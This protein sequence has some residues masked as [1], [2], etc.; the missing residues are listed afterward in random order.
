MNIL[1]AMDENFV[2][3]YMVLLVSLFE[4]NKVPIKVFLL[5]S[6]LSQSSRDKFQKLTSQY[7]NE[8]ICI[9]EDKDQFSDFSVGEWSVEAF[10]RL[11]AFAKL[12]ELVD[13]IL[14]LDGDVV[15]RQGI[16]E[17]YNMEFQGNYYIACEDESI[18]RY[19]N[20][21]EYK[22]L[23]FTRDTPYINTGVLL[24]NIQ[25]LRKEKSAEDFILFMKKHVN[26]IKYPDQSTINAMFRDKIRIV[27]G[28][29]YNCQVNAYHYTEA[30]TILKNAQI[31]HYA[32]SGQ[33]PWNVE[34]GRHFAT[35]IPGDIWWNYQRI[36][37]GKFNIK[38]L[39]W[40]IRNTLYVKPWQ[41]CYRIYRIIS[42]KEIKK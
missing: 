4:T 25:K 1:I 5:Y 11:T 6:N 22:R 41:I 21:D 38:Y 13:R 34:C 39:W 30:E 19:K 14:W 20:P 3:Y 33:R 27:E 36:L 26:E 10:Y 8:L 12:P 9:Y 37:D 16:S 18:S 15:V 28:L 42:P 40:K 7:G 17:F 31:I 23:K 35:A 24:I 29:K 2:Y 32:G